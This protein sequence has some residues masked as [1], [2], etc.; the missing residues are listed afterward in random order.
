MDLRENVDWIHLVRNRDQRRALVNTV[1]DFRVPQNARNFLTRGANIRV[2][3]ILFH[4]ELLAMII[5]T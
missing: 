5:M 4:G 3:I 1:M 2:S